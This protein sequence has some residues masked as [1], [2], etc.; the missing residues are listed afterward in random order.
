MKKQFNIHSILFFLILVLMISCGEKVHR[1][2][3]NLGKTVKI[4]YTADKLITVDV[5]YEWYFLAKPKGSRAFLLVDNDK[6]LFNPDVTGEFDILVSV[7]DQF[8]KEVDKKG[9]YYDVVPGEMEKSDAAAADT[10]AVAEEIPVD[11]Q[12]ETKPAPPPEPAAE[13]DIDTSSVTAKPK[14]EPPTPAEVEP[15][16]KEE[17]EVTEPQEA[18]EQ[19]RTPAVTSMPAGPPADAY[20]IQISAWKT[21]R[22][23][24]REVRRLE[25]AGFSAH[26]EMYFDVAK[27][28]LWYRVRLDKYNDYAAARTVLNRVNASPG[29]SGII[30][31]LYQAEP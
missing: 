6:A 31:P 8:G 2:T 27:D 11:E 29:F 25:E 20:T 14:E 24:L 13:P 15:P 3:I 1:E 12:P 19:T 16:V 4:T 9:Y 21:R 30:V 28:L 5:S 10:E 7:V 23:A 26:I 18:P 22:Y 17:P